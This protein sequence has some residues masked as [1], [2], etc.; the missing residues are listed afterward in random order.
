MPDLISARH[1]I[2]RFR[3]GPARAAEVAALRRDLAAHPATATATATATAQAA[4]ATEHAA[5]QELRRLREELSRA[6][7][8]VQSCRGCARGYPLPHGRWDGG[9][10]CGARTRDLFNDD[11]LAALRLGGTRPRDLPLPDPAQQPW[12][13]ESCGCAFRG[14]TGCSLRPADRPNLCV[15]YVCPELSRELH[16]RGDLDAI[17]AL[18][19]AVEATY[20]RFVKARAER[21]EAQEWETTL[22]GA[23]PAC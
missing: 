1:L 6:I 17:E 4:L 23:E 9:H 13:A 19:A 2:D 16:A 21:L 10:C 15:R 11:E 20:L 5:A 14:A 8:A 12:Q 22:S 7:G 18:G 3:H